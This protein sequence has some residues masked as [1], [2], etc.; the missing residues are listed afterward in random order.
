MRN[1]NFLEKAL[2][3]V[4]PPHFEHFSCYILLTD[5]MLLLMCIAI[6]C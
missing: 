3:I 2:E 4:S 1:F 5:Q 6:V